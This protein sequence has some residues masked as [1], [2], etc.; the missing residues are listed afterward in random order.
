M[1]I[2]VTQRNLKPL[3]KKKASKTILAEAQLVTGQIALPP[4]AERVLLH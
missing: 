4:T 1:K 3:E 2:K